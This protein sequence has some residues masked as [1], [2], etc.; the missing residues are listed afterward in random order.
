MGWTVTAHPGRLISEPLAGEG[1]GT[2]I[3]LQSAGPTELWG[4]PDLLPSKQIRQGENLWTQ[5]F[6]AEPARN[7]ADRNPPKRISLMR[8]PLVR[9]AER[10]KAERCARQQVRDRFLRTEASVE[11]GRTDP[12]NWTNRPVTVFAPREIRRALPETARCGIRL[13]DPGMTSRQPMSLS[14]FFGNRKD[15]FRVPC[16][17]LGIPVQKWSDRRST[18]RHIAVM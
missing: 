14:E 3:K 9:T 18:R 13:S 11:F 15:C 4:E 2:C 6:P 8:P 17:G 5:R 7:A 16:L 12:P 10:F 1:S